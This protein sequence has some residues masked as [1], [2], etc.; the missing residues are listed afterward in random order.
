MKHKLYKFA[1]LTVAGVVVVSMGACKKN[2]QSED[3]HTETSTTQEEMHSD[4]ITTNI[5]IT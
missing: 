3:P 2:I 5:A 1:S 4:F